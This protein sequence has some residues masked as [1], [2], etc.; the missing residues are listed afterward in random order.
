[1]REIRHDPTQLRISDEERH[2]VAEILREAAG[3][4]RLD[5]DELDARLEATYA[6]R[7]TP[8]SSRSPS[9]CRPRD[10]QPAGAAASST[11][12]RRHQPRQTSIA[13]MGGVQPAGRLAGAGERTR[14]SRYGRRR[15]R[16]ARATFAGPR[17]PSPP[18]RSWAGSRSSST[19]RTNVVVS[20]VPIMGEFHQAKDKVDPQLGPE[21]PIVRVK[22]HRPDG[23][24][25]RAAP[26]TPGYAQEDPRH[27]LIPLRRGAWVPGRSARS[28]ARGVAPPG[29][30]RAPATALPLSPRRPT[31]EPSPRR[32]TPAAGESQTSSTRT[33]V[34]VSGR[35][36]GIQNPRVA[37]P[38]PVTGRP[39]VGPGLR[40]RRGHARPRLARRA[41]PR[42]S[43]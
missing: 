34:T 16:P 13:I 10:P 18:T 4:G 21:A 26:P 37:E 24:R 23:R 28:A 30:E 32:R 29:A 8:T 3:E 22:R 39:A 19:R 33:S 12:S 14:R 31:T 41:P 43:A 15:P 20:G 40:Q 6:A 7:P 2:Q 1:M 9:T 35:L 38:A 11:S 5:L 27:V 25:H 36:R 17:S 42:R